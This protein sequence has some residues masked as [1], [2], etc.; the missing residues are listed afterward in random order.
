MTWVE[1][2]DQSGGIYNVNKEFG[3]KIPMLI[4]DLCEYNKAYI[5][6][7]GKI[8]VTDLNNDPYDKKISS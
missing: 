6:V 5:V 1:I 3:F 7:T 8:T 4:S 2:Y